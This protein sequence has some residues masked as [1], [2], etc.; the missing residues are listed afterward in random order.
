MLP[1]TAREF[2]QQLGGACVSTEG[3]LWRTLKL[4]LTQPGELTVQYPEGRR[5]HSVLPLRLYLTIGVA[6]L[7]LTR[8]LGGTEVAGGL[9]KPELRAKERGE[10]DTLVFNSESFILGIRS[11]DFV[12]TGLPAALFA[13]VRQRAAPDARTLPQRLR[14]ANER[15]T[16]NFGIVMFVV[17]P[18]FAACLQLVNRGSGLV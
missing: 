16:A 3:A 6:L 15:L 12:C 11:G 10:F 17:L 7:L 1:P 14:L 9:Y 4:L 8:V 5:K 2:A 13:L 18:L